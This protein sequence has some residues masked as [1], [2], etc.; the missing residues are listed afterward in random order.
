MLWNIG[1]ITMRRCMQPLPLNLSALGVAWLHRSCHT[2]RVLL[3]QAHG[4]GGHQAPSTQAATGMSE[5]ENLALC[6]L[7]G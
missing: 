5:A 1:M 2:H 7:V 6:N 3:P 4:N